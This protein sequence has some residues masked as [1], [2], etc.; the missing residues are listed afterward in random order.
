VSHPIWSSCVGSTLKFCN[1]KALNC[2]DDDQSGLHDDKL[3]CIKKMGPNLFEL[4]Y[5]RDSG[6]VSSKVPQESVLKGIAA[7]MSKYQ[8][9]CYAEWVPRFILSASQGSLVDVDSWSSP[10]CATTSLTSRRRGGVSSPSSEVQS[11]SRTD[12]SSCC[13]EG[14]WTM[15]RG[16]VSQTPFSSSRVESCCESIVLELLLSARASRSKG[17]E[18]QEKDAPAQAVE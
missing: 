15:R 3:M 14:N 17:H 13:S 6:E 12:D 4:R 8:S 11:P 2:S 16:G 1:L 10:S 9:C 5:V 7:W 18:R